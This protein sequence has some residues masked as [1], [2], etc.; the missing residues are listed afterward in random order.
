M[1]HGQAP[2]SK[3]ISQWKDLENPCSHRWTGGPDESMPFGG[4]GD[5]VRTDRGGADSS[6][7]T[8][9]DGQVYLDAGDPRV[10]TTGT[11]LVK[12]NTGSVPRCL[13]RRFSRVFQKDK[14]ERANVMSNGDSCCFLPGLEAWYSG[15]DRKRNR[16]LSSLLVPGD[17]T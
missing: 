9:S 15:D 6:G 16:T 13:P 2:Q 4:Q 10:L 17:G 1:H 14:G 8:C 3:E 11:V 5:T 12:R 7:N